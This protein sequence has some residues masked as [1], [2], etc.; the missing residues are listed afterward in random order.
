MNTPPLAKHVMS[1]FL[2][3]WA[4]IE[5]LFWCHTDPSLLLEFCAPSVDRRTFP[6]NAMSP[7]CSDMPQP[8]SW[9]TGFFFFMV[10]GIQLSLEEVWWFTVVEVCMFC[11]LTNF[12]GC[13]CQHLEIWEAAI[14]SVLPDL[15]FFLGKFYMTFWYMDIKKK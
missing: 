8:F 6:V 11:L 14:L 15:S 10:Q 4:H 2:C 1:G 13:L 3:H 12:E 5:S 7:V 9:L